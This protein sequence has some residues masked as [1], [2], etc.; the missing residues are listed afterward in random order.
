[1]CCASASAFRIE[2]RDDSARATSGARSPL[3]GFGRNL[4]AA[5]R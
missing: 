4:V 1:M 3:S 5:A 2:E